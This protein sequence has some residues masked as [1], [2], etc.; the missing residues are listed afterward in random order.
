MGNCPVLG[1]DPA[2]PAAAWAEGGY[3]RG[4]EGAAIGGSS[5]GVW[6]QYTPVCQAGPAGR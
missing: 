2:S 6:P 4:G 5:C 3:G 1:A